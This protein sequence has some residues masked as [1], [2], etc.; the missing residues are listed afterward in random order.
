MWWQDRLHRAHAWQLAT[1]LSSTC[2]GCTAL[3]IQA[4][5]HC[6]P[7]LVV[8]H[9]P[10]WAQFMSSNLHGL[11]AT[12][13]PWPPP[14]QV[15]DAWAWALGMHAFSWY[16]QIHPG[17]AVL[18]GRKPALLDSLS[19]VRAPGVVLLA[20]LRR[21]V[22]WVGGQQEGMG[23]SRGAALAGRRVQPRRAGSSR[24]GQQGT[25]W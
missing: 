15:P 14:L 21:W 11:L 20:A 25:L 2:T 3:P 16:M 9:A 7:H 12:R 1:P 6:L 17:H 5:L 4:G 23:G 10:D 24:E 19:Q 18:E 22:W 8:L 13:P